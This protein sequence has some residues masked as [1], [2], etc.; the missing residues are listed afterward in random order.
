MKNIENRGI[1]ATDTL[2]NEF[3]GKI[4]PLYRLAKRRKQP[5]RYT[6]SPLKLVGNYKTRR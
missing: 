2:K 6:K 5:E 3:T 1:T 4:K